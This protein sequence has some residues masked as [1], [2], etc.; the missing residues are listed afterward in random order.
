[1]NQGRDADRLRPITVR[2][3]QGAYDAIQDTADDNCISKAELVRMAVAG[4]LGRY[5]GTI[6]VIGPRQAEELKVEIVRLFTVIS[7]VRNELNKI[8]VNY[9]QVV[10]N[11][12]GARKYGGTGVE[13]KEGATLPI[14]ELDALLD[15]YVEATE[16]VRNLCRI[17][18]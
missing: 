5:L 6:K 16:G 11:F 8:G 15:R 3:S 12:N 4:N 2:F 9:N 17:L 7:E 14:G 1:M 18:M 10:K 13:E